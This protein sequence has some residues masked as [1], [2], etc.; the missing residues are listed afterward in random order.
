MGKTIRSETI[1][2]A[3]EA[4]NEELGER[5]VKAGWEWMPGT[6]DTTGHRFICLADCGEAFW[7]WVAEDGCD[8]LPVAGRYPDLTD[9]ATLGCLLVLVS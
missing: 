3:G 4:T 6:L 2:G 8:V 7:I 5:A 9:P 1:N